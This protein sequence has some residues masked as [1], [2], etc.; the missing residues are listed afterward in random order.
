VR[1]T[2]CVPSLADQQDDGANATAANEESVED[3]SSLTSAAAPSL[4]RMD[5]NGI[6]RSVLILGLLSVGAS[7]YSM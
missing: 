1:D 2:Y 4:K 7:W 3:S 5:G 6:A